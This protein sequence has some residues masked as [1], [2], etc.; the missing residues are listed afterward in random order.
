MSNYTPITDFSVKD[1]LP[2]G[3][4]AKLIKGADF[5]PEFDAISTAVAS[6][7]NT[8][9]PTFTGTVV[10]PALTFNG[11]LITGTIEGGTY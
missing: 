1:G 5:D 7:S 11:T 10:I 3:N 4:A 9:S 2:T 8:A 6:K